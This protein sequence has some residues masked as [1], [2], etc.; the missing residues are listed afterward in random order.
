M[1][2]AFGRNG[3]A[4]RSES[5][6]T[7]LARE[8]LELLA[9]VPPS[10]ATV[11]LYASRSKV[12][13]SNGPTRAGQPSHASRGSSERT[14]TPWR[15]HSHGPPDLP[16]VVRGSTASSGRPPRGGGAGL[17]ELVT[18]H[19]RGRRL[20]RTRRHLRRR[21]PGRHRRLPQRI[22]L[23]RVD[24]LLRAVD[25]DRST[26]RGRPLPDRV[27]RYPAPSGVGT[28]RDERPHVRSGVA[29]RAVRDNR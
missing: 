8:V 14:R 13:A 16:G 20:R 24:P 6:L 27:L 26:R 3:R 2:G 22:G 10:R 29:E 19:R 1:F 4:P 28:L 5:E 7:G 21:R 15:W 17:G 11:T 18:G 12:A 25:G 23:G 9:D